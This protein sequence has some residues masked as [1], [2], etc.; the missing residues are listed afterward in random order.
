MG[1]HMHKVGTKTRKTASGYPQQLTLYQAQNCKGC[2]LRGACHKA[3]GNRIIEVNHRLRAYRQLARK[4]LNSEQGIRKRK[5]R[6]TEVEAVFGILK[7]NHGFK[8]FSLRGKLKV[9]IETGLHA[10]AHNF[11]KLAAKT[12]QLATFSSSNPALAFQRA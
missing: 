11:R 1:Q 3:E 8:R 12:A 2:P 4:K 6:C 10:L 5:R 9:E 7:H